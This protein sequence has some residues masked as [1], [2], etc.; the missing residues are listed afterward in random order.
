ML[1][2]RAVSEMAR[3]TLLTLLATL[4]STQAGGC[5]LLEACH[6]PSSCPALAGMPPAVFDTEFA[7]TAG[8][9]TIRTI[10]S[11]APP[12]A[13][14]FWNLAQISYMVG[15]PFYRVDRLNA[16]TG[17]V[18]QFGYSGEPQVD[19]CW[20]RLRTSN[21]TW[22]VAAPGNVAGSVAFSMDAVPPSPELK[23]C[24]SSEYC[25]RGF[26]T[27]I[28]INYQDNARR[29]DPPAFSPFGFVLPPGMDVVNQLFSDY[30]EVK[31]L[32]PAAGSTH[33]N[34]DLFCKGLGDACEGV[35]MGRLV[36][37]GRPYFQREKPR[38]DTILSMRVKVVEAAWPP[39]EVRVDAG[40]PVPPHEDSPS[41]KI[42]GSRYTSKTRHQTARRVVEEQQT[43]GAVDSAEA[44]H[45]STASTAWYP[46]DEL[47]V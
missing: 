43:G 44:P 40:A 33:A 25:A 36:A 47:R 23:N 15:G 10:T 34:G 28:F 22:S 39:G 3:A 1:G 38:L 18:V 41:S 19:Q 27:N 35:D 42:A 16:T 29:L 37:E 14:R 26:S 30:G 24:T 11:W 9:F 17:W 20:D 8:N 6:R 5:D 7:T 45:E 2:Q 12:Y 46:H 32:C 13:R 31:E 21:E 4:P